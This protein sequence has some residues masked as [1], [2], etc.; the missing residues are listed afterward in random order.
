[1]GSLFYSGNVTDTCLSFSSSFD[2]L[3]IRSYSD[4]FSHNFYQL[5]NCCSQGNYFQNTF[6]PWFI[7]KYFLFIRKQSASEKSNMSLACILCNKIQKTSIL[8]SAYV[9]KSWFLERKTIP[10]LTCDTW[11]WLQSF[12]QLH[13]VLQCA[14]G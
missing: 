3:C 7:Y 4:L 6:Q 12:W 13:Q 5:S 14:D 11:D 2:N 8:G 10:D 1:M 9:L